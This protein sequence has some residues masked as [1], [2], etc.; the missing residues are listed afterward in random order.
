MKIVLSAV[1]IALLVGCSDDNV[2]TQK[3]IETKK[4]EIATPKVAKETKI[5]IKTVQKEAAVVVKTPVKREE[6]IA[7]KVA[8]KSEKIVKK[9]ES[10]VVSPVVDGQALYAKCVACH[11]AKA[12]KKALNKSQVIQGW[13]IAK[14]TKALKGYKDGSYGG[15]MKTVMQ[16]QIKKYSDE[17]IQAVAK[18]ILNITAN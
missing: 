12:E 15:S 14:T 11:G 3:T 8:V 2:A 7:P 6:K 5:I 10:K 4:V 18:Y 9:T 1:L 13:S 16:S 17:E